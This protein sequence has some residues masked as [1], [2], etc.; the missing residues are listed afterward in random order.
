MSESEKKLTIQQAVEKYGKYVGP[1]VGVSM[2]PMLKERRDTIVVL[3]KESRLKELDVA[4]Y[5][6]EQDVVLHRV[7]RVLE[8][9]YLI[10]GDNTYKDEYVKENEVFGVLTE[11]FQADKRILCTDE[12]YLK[13][14]KKRVKSYPRRRLFLRLKGKAVNAIRKIFPKRK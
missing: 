4:L 12:K 5:T 14:A 6:R 11:F 3:K 8:D 9:G 7:I 1:T 13:Y 10:R 2:L